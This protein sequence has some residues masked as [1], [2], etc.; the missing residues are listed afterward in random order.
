M[1][2]PAFSRGLFRTA[3]RPLPATVA[4]VEL[5]LAP[6]EKNLGGSLG[7]RDVTHTQVVVGGC[8][9]DATITTTV[10]LKNTKGLQ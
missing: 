8:L 4:G 10:T 3:A 9:L 2:P 1:I 5:S 7:Y 6:T